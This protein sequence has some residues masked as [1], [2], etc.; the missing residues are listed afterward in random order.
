MNIMHKATVYRYW[1]FVIF[2]S[3]R[4]TYDERTSDTNY[5]LSGL[6][7]CIPPGRHHSSHCPHQVMLFNADTF[8]TENDVI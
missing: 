7:Q 2:F 3:H 8:Q 5:H 4:P 1:V 6:Y